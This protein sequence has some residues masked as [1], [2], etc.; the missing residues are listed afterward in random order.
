M[1]GASNLDEAEVFPN[2]LG[3]G[4]EA[5]RGCLKHVTFLAGVNSHCGMAAGLLRVSNTHIV[6]VQIA[7]VTTDLV[8][9]I[10]H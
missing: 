1:S 4:V 8:H 3:R 7:R 9:N 10:H 5:R 6:Q 2:V